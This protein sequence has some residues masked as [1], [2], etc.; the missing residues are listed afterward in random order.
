M[1]E[2]L[3]VQTTEQSS[4]RAEYTQVPGGTDDALHRPDY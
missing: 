4:R 1:P 2:Y 3:V